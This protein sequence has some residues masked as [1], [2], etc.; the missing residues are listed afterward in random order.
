MQK[1]N[2]IDI[3]FYDEVGSTQEEA[4]RLIHSG[5]ACVGHVISTNKQTAG[6]GRYKRAWN[7]TER[8]IAITIILQATNTPSHKLD[9][10]C[11]VAGIAVAQTILHFAG[12]I[13]L[14]LK[15]V[16][17]ILLNGK[18]VGGI[19]IERVEHNFVLVGMGINLRQSQF[20]QQYNATALDIEGIQVEHRTFLDALMQNFFLS[21]NS[22]VE[23]GFLPIRNRWMQ[24]VAGLNQHIKITLADKSVTGIFTDIDK[25]GNIMLLEGGE[26]QLISTGEL[27]LERD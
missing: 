2:A 12:N 16:N 23:Y 9:Q 8:D 5:R 6:Y 17:D 26:L 4:K 7:G 27:F 3:K 13:D 20:L 10:L 15:W 1:I 25:D 19:L 18:K 24:L 14:K 21:Y 22:W 11:Y